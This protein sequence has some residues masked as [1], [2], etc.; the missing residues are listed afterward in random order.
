MD[1]ADTDCNHTAVG[2][3]VGRIV[4]DIVEEDIGYIGIDIG[5]I[6]VVV[7]AVAD[8]DGEIGSFPGNR[9]CPYHFW[10]YLDRLYRLYRLF[11]CNHL[12]LSWC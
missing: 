7:V 9:C 8:I 2:D 12:F 4:V 3:V 1:T 11:L 10:L 5:Y 6:V